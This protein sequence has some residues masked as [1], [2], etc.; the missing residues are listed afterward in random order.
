MG[1]VEARPLLV[2]LLRE[3]P[4]TEMIDAAASVADE[5]CIIL[6]GRLARTCP[7]LASA[8]VGVLAQL[9]HFGV[10]PSVRAAEILD[11]ARRQPNCG[12]KFSRVP[13]T[14]SS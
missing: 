2:R 8:V 4:S 12:A 7:D 11:S 13:A 1:R 5:A 9:P 10:L 14:Q 3:E 6:L